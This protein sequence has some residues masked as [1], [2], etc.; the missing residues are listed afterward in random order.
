MCDSL[1][2]VGAETAGGAT[3]FAKNSDR[4][5]GECQ[6]L[7]QFPE[8]FHPPGA[9]LR[10][11]HVEIPQVDHTL[12][13]LGHSPWWV[14]GFEHGVNECGV[15]IGNQ[16]VFS[17]DPVEEKPGL[18]GM[19]LV[20]LALERSRSAREAVETI[21]KLLEA[22]GQGGSAFAPGAAGY[23]NSFAVADPREAWLVETSGRRFA[24]RRARRDALSN[25]LCL[26]ADWELGSPDLAEHARA[27][28]W[29]EGAGRLDLAGAYR[30]PGVPGRI[31]EGRWRRSR[32]L[33]ARAGRGVDVGTLEGVLRDHADGG[34]VR[35][36]GSTTDEERYF[37][38][39]MHSEPVGTTTASLVAE[40]PVD[41]SHPWPVWVS[42]ATPCTGIF[43]PV[44]LD[45]VIPAELARGGESY[46]AGSAW[47]T[48]ERLQDAA[49]ADFVSCTPR[50]RAAWSKLEAEIE[51]G[52]AE[53]ES[54][55][56][57]EPDR[58]AAAKLLSEFMG[59]TVERA[60]VEARH[61]TD[62][63]RA[64]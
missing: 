33:L 32:E 22:H 14:W 41:R 7:L 40:L 17:R 61:L 53:V 34:P 48:F 62:S 29:W 5:A 21:A 27:E 19:D 45:G 9:R 18:I 37:T 60:L 36:A 24:A 42:F 4:K 59:R 58:D 55:A 3:L 39:C 38:L 49:S 16:T 30:N 46:E 56:A 63:I 35:L 23:H 44:Y 52:R 28:G 50:L 26:G 13:V 11:T 20:R 43:L 51:G 10:C 31:S 2:A 25:H 54:A 64:A 6:P 12:R 8:S 47:W 15:A 1:V 57:G